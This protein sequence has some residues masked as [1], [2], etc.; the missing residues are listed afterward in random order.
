MLEM[1]ERQISRAVNLP[2]LKEANFSSEIDVRPG[3]P[4][5][6]CVLGRDNGEKVILKTG[7]PSRIRKEVEGYGL[8]PDIFPKPEIV[9]V[10]NWGIEYEFFEGNELFT[11]VREDN[12]VATQTYKDYVDRTLLM[13]AENTRSLGEAATVYDHAKLTANTLGKIGK[14]LES[15]RVGF[16]WDAPMVINGREHPSLKETFA[17][18]RSLVRDPERVVL[19]VGDANGSNIL[20]TEDGRW[21]LIDFEKAG[22]YDPAYIVARQVGQW[23]LT[24]KD[25]NEVGYVYEVHGNKNIIN[26][27][28]NFPTLVPQM[29]IL[30]IDL[31]RYLSSVGDTS[32]GQRAAYYQLV[33][34]ARMAVLSSSRFYGLLRQKDLSKVVLAKAVE[35]F[36][37]LIN[38]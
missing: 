5:Y 2:K 11:L 29:E 35:G 26:Y 34:L 1:V 12:P 28:A 36:Y 17:L 9:S 30:V 7:I 8:V 16:L 18:A 24:V 13:W 22:W 31:G 19:D 20:I 27:E 21:V 23:E 3:S 33:F 14:S 25:P 10:A 6:V 15:G 4:F 38:H 37:Q 32:W